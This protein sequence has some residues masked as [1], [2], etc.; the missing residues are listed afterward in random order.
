MNVPLLN[1]DT[2]IQKI[3]WGFS[4]SVV[5]GLDKNQR[6]CYCFFSLKTE[7]SLL[8]YRIRLHFTISTL[9]RTNKQNNWVNW[10]SSR[11]TVLIKSTGSVAVRA[12]VLP[13]DTG[14]TLSPWLAPFLLLSKCCTKMYCGGGGRSSEW[15][16][17]HFR[18]VFIII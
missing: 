15:C 14:T 11:W 13:H 16:D 1:P 9:R 10:Y 18:N 2:D 12:C 4:T 8:S 5:T 17:L 6:L 3:I 7:P